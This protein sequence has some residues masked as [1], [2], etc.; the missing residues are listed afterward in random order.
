MAAYC[1]GQ[2]HRFS[3]FPK[4]QHVARV[5]NVRVLSDNTGGYFLITYGFNFYAAFH[6]I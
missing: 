6:Q 4:W 2:Q 5:L 1:A 3:L